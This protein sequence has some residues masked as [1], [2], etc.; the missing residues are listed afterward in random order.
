MPVSQVG[1]VGVVPGG[2]SGP[3]VAA[4]V[5][6]TAKVAVKVWYLAVMVAV[7]GLT[8]NSKNDH[9]VESSGGHW[10]LP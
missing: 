7:P 8:P 5:T 1:T 6:V 4:A 10:V 3:G 2:K 9:D